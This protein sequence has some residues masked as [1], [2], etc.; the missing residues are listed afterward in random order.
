[1]QNLEKWQKIFCPN[2]TPI[3]Q[4]PS[5]KGVEVMVKR[6]DLNH[7]I[8]QGNKLRKLKYNLKYALE[9]NYTQLATF[10]GAYS[11]HLL[12][13]AQAAQLTNL[14]SIGFVRGDELA[15]QQHKWS[16]TL[17]QARQLGMKLIFLSRKEYR[18]KYNASI[19]IK[20]LSRQTYLIPEGGSNALALQGVAEIM[21]ELSAQIEPPTHIITACGTGGT[22]AGLIDGVA[23][24]KWQ[25]KVIGIS[26]LKG[27]NFLH[28]YITNLTKS[29]HRVNWEIWLNYHAGGYA[30]TTD[31]VTSFA[32]KFSLT[33]TIPLDKIYTSKS[34][35]AVYDLIKQGR[36]APNNKV[37]I[38][39]TGGLQG[40]CVYSSDVPQE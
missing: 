29:H 21:D 16:Y 13:T 39:H 18:L 14:K 24:T 31:K 32:R 37:V 25:T 2:A 28:Q 33:N 26:V 3:Q 38:L 15:S 36:I 34:F 5:Y 19:V 12:A 11:N 35:F 30:K 27:A 10:G 8:I 23:Q 1:M 22:L 7:K 40:G 17:T 20:H 4:L 6:D 9:H